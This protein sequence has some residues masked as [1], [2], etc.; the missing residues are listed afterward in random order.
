MTTPK[1]DNT[2]ATHNGT[3]NSKQANDNNLSGASRVWESLRTGE[4][5]A[6]TQY[7]AYRTAALTQQS[8]GFLG[9]YRFRLK[10]SWKMWMGIAAGIIGLLMLISPG[11]F[12]QWQL[13]MLIIITLVGPLI[14]EL[15]S[16]LQE[17]FGN[18]PYKHFVGQTV[19]LTQPIMDGKSKLQLDDRDW[20][21]SGPNCKVGTQVKIIALDAKTLYVTPVT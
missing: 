3:H 21:V 14:M 18:Q 4:V 16:T 19:T 15:I 6:K 11:S 1:P 20:L 2:N 8:D 7:Y 5:K 9:Q 13:P 10:H 17:Y 12:W